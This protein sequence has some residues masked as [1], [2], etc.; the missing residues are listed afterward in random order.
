MGVA[1]FLVGKKVLQDD[2]HAV[3]AFFHLPQRLL[4]ALVKR[5][6]RISR[7]HQHAAPNRQIKPLRQ[8]ANRC[9]G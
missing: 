2:Q 7:D 5:A 8:T 9:D 6:G 3:V 4:I 1:V